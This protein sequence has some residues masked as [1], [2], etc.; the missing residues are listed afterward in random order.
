MK[1]M[2]ATKIFTTQGKRRKW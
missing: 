2:I 1:Q